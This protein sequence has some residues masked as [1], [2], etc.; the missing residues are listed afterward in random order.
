MGIL[1]EIVA[2]GAYFIEIGA[3]D[4]DVWSQLMVNDIGHNVKPFLNEVRQ[5]SLII[6]QKTAGAKLTKTNCWDFKECGRT[7][8]SKGVKELVV[9]PA[10]SETRLHR[11]NAGKNGGRCCWLIPGT[12]CGGRIQRSFVPKSV[13]CRRCNFKSFVLNEENSNCI[14]SDK[15]L[16]MLIH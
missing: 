2:R 1:K 16:N 4:F 6:V 11:I 3:S 13:A 9:C 10:F 15:F 12:L 7:I 8:E 14:V 5:W